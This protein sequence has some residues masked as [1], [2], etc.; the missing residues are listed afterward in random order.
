[1][2]KLYH[3][4]LSPS[5]RFIRL[6]ISEYN[7][8]VELKTQIP[9]IRDKN[10]LALNPSGD[11]PVLEDEKVGIISGSRVI[12]EWLEEVIDNPLFMPK[13]P[14]ER[15]EVRRIVDWFEDKFSREVSRPII[16][17]RIIKRFKNKKTASS[18]ILRQA[19]SNCNIHLDYLNWLASQN[20]WMAG[21]NITLSDLV[22]GGYL[23]VL[24]YFG[25]INWN[26]Y[27]DVKLW[28]MK[29]KSRPSFSSILNDVILGVPPSSHYK[30]IDF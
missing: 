25:D 7:L 4:P 15:I 29:L 20:N 12:S 14:E 19:L 1:M 22:G 26:K 11:V 5:S 16:R 2:T 24:D 6:Q 9:W 13:N 8:E 28:Y 10:F 27:N 18:E 23:S 3:Y 30:T 17:E 21:N